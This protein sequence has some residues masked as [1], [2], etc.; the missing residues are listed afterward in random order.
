MQYAVNNFSK[1][2]LSAPTEPEF[3]ARKTT[4]TMF[5]KG[6]IDTKIKKFVDRDEIK[7]E[8]LKRAFTILHGKCTESLL[9][10]LEGDRKYEDIE[11]DQ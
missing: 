1:P 2:T 5:Q 8:N 7:E 10:K 11:S 9:D 3:E 4:L 6:I